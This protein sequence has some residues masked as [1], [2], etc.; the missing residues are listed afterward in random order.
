MMTRGGILLLDPWKALACVREQLN[1][2][3]CHKEI[4]LNKEDLRDNGLRHQTDN[5]DPAL[6][7]QGGPDSEKE[8]HHWW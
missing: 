6:E 8:L 7:T 2:L 1:S 4:Y 3:K 5:L